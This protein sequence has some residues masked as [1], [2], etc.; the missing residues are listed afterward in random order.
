MEQIAVSFTKDW[1][2]AT[3]LTPTV[4]ILGRDGTLFVNNDSCKEIWYWWYVYNFQRYSADKVYLYR[5][6]WGDT[7]SDYDRYK[8]WGNEFDAYTNKY[9]WGRTAAPYFTSV[10]GRF[11]RVDKTIKDFMKDV[12]KSRKEYDDSAVRKDLSE[13]K[14]IVNWKWGYDLADKLIELRRM[15]EEVNNAIKTESS[16]KWVNE[17]NNKLDML[18]EYNVKTKEDVAKGL[19]FVWDS[20]MQWLNENSQMLNEWVSKIATAEQLLEQ[21]NIITNKMQEVLDTFVRTNIEGS[22]PKYITDRY[23]VNL[24]SRD[25]DSEML[26]AALNQ[27]LSEWIGEWMNEGIEEWMSEWL[28][29]G[30]EEWLESARE[31]PSN[32]PVDMQW[33]AE[34]TMPNQ[35]M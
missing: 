11:D 20:I 26:R 4:T 15:I 25:E 8:F 6:D 13:I 29:M 18:A 28:D 23:D 2:P 16:S 22:L 9:S 33:I 1:S 27:W 35:P 24:S 32:A 5:F 17:L 7:L 3:W 19:W 30:M 34:P 10:N 14:N 12:K 31:M 21:V